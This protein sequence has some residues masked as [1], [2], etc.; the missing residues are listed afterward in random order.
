MTLD[1][2]ASE[3]ENWPRERIEAVMREVFRQRARRWVHAYPAATPEQAFLAGHLSCLNGL[4]MAVAAQGPTPLTLDLLLR[5]M[6][7]D[8]SVAQE[9]LKQALRG[10]DDRPRDTRGTGEPV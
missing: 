6:T 8:A 3:P 5:A 1:D 9:V 4:L 10:Q 2:R 7:H